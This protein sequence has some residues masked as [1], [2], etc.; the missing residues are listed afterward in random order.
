M[1]DLVER[2]KNLNSDIVDSLK[3]PLPFILVRTESNS[4]I[5]CE[6]TDDRSAYFFNF[7]HPFEIDDDKRIIH[8]VLRRRII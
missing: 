2:N 6:V 7:S 1:K 5:E 4:V 8:Q 3:V